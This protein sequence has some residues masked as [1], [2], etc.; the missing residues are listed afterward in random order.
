MR[1]CA[2]ALALALSPAPPARADACPPA[3]AVR[4][5][6][7][8]QGTLRFPPTVPS[9]LDYRHRLQPTPLG[10]PT[11]DHWC[12]WIEPTQAEPGTAAAQREQD[13]RQAALAG[14]KPWR[15]LLAINLVEHPEQAQIRLW[16][17]RPPLQRLADGRS[18]ASNGRAVL[19]VLQVNRGNGWQPE[20]RVE[21]LLSPGRAPLAMQATALHELGHA[22][23]LWGHSDH[24]GDAMA[25]VPS[26]A[27]VLQLSPRDRATLQWLQSQHERLQTP[28]A[29]A[30]NPA[31]APGPR[32]APKA[33]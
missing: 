8:A 11:R 5:L 15:D 21:V 28:A 30:E 31:A 29:P 16:R 25:A 4:E 3:V 18:R 1:A 24:P 2:L 13:W 26:G 10:W 14:L 20:P 19:L 23:G 22:F 33:D 7:V 27:P 17:R 9:G 32:P 12:V 6:P